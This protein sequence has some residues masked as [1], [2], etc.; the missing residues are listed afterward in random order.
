MPR[1]QS[2]VRQLLREKEAREQRTITQAVMAEETELGDPTIWRYVSDKIGRP[3]PKTVAKLAA[4][5]GVD[6]RDLLTL[7]D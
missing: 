2:N 1:F 4:Y 7:V 5:F 6:W 3:E